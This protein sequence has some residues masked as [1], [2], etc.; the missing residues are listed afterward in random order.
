M[1]E[2]QHQSQE[3]DTLLSRL[4]R[5]NAATEIDELRQILYTPGFFALLKT[6]SPTQIGMLAR[7]LFDCAPQC[8]CRD[9]RWQNQRSR[10]AAER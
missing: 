7:V 6:S 5:V 9:Q 2:D 1:C 3:L 4:N 10:A 8:R